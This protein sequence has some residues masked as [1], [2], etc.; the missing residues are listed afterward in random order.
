MTY[1]ATSLVLDSFFI[2]LTLSVVLLSISTCC[3][4]VCVLLPLPPLQQ[5]WVIWCSHVF[6]L[7]TCSSVDLCSRVS[8]HLS[9]LLLCLTLCGDSIGG[10]NWWCSH[11]FSFGKWHGVPL[12]FL[13]PPTSYSHYH[14]HWHHFNVILD[15]IHMRSVH[16]LAPWL[17]DCYH[18]L[19]H[20][21]TTDHISFLGFVYTFGT[22]KLRPLDLHFLASCYDAATYSCHGWLLELEGLLPIHHRHWFD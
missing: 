1:H 17:Y 14:C 19:L 4:Y 11:I 15:L 18:H 3:A 13:P 7:F 2:I 21:L 22:R 9:I 8:G 6:E 20:V 16:A 12:L 5:F 10:H